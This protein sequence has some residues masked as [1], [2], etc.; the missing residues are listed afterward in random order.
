MVYFNSMAVSC[1]RAGRPCFVADMDLSRDRSLAF[2][3]EFVS[4]CSEFH[5]RDIVAVSRACGL[6]TNTVERWKYGLNYPDKERAEEVLAWVRAG[7]PMKQ[8][9][10]FPDSSML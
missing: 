5:Y 6:A 7:K 10:P 3:D 2:W 1:S 9:R 4:A 8:Q